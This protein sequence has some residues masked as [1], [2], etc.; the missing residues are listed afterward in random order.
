MAAKVGRSSG[1]YDNKVYD[2]GEP[3]SDYLMDSPGQAKAKFANNTQKDSVKAYS[4]V[5][6]TKQKLSQ[7]INEP[8]DSG[9]GDGAQKEEGGST[10]RDYKPKAKPYTDSRKRDAGNIGPM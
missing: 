1:D 6:S 5:E 7:K 4:G 2:S 8:M 3:C 9:E 10:T